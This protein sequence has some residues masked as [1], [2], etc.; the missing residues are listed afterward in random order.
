M[1]IARIDLA[2]AAS[3]ERIVIEI[4]KHEPDLPIP[5]P[6]EDLCR[7]LDIVDITPLTTSGF[8]GG[9]ITDVNKHSG[10]ILYNQASPAKRRR[11]TIAHELAHFLMPS[12]VPGKDGQ[13]L[14]SQ[15]DMFLL[16][17][18]EQDRR[19]RMEFE[20]N[21]FASLV[22]LPPPRFRL[23]VG[24]SKDPNLRH[25]IELSDKY[26]VSLEA[27]GRAYVTYRNDPVALIVTQHG[28]VLR[29]Y[30]DER[31]FP[32]VTIPYNSPVPHNSLLL[33]KMHQQGVP[34]D[35]DETNAGVWINVER[36]RQ[37]PVLWEQ[38][39]VQQQGFA[40]IMLALEQ[41][42]DDEYDRDADRTAKERYRDRQTRWGE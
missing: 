14:C 35:I 28:R 31:R 11:F 19:S 5:V 21:R 30:K 36:G 34:S 41:N 4:L 13:F 26:Q 17:T 23:D 24:R 33:R 1:A 2:D 42:E 27:L 29:Y 10:I 39:H 20:A 6:I 12:H 9:L 22:L 37:A 25:I 38:V 15:R 7:K 8:E 32:F 40:L 18:S 3:P 16:S